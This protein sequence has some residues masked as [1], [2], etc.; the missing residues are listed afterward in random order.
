MASSPP[1][2][3]LC[4]Q[5]R[6][7][8]YELAREQRIAANKRAVE[9]FD[10]GSAARQLVAHRAISK[11]TRSK[12]PRV[13]LSSKPRRSQRQTASKPA[14]Y[15]KLSKA[16]LTRFLKSMST[17]ASPPSTS[18]TLVPQAGP[19]PMPD[20]LR[21]HSPP[22][23][24]SPAVSKMAEGLERQRSV[25]TL[26]DSFCSTAA[27]LGHHFAASHRCKCTQTWETI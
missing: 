14:D 7:N 12:R 20:F 22:C 10:C 3:T 8:P 24:S 1:A 15:R 16:D 21:K 5:Q 9:A 19:T 25:L 13:I 2:D 4:V 18:K 23:M 11:T 17:P 6:A 26:G 27:C